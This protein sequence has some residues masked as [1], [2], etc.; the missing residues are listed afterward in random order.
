MTG[1]AAVRDDDGHHWFV[2]RA[3]DVIVASG[4]NVGPFEVESAIVLHPA[5]AESA[6][7]G[8]SRRGSVVKAFVVLGDD[9]VP[10]DALQAL[11]SEKVGRHASPREVEFIAE[12]PRTTRPV[13]HAG[14]AAPPPR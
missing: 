3:G 1:D 13:P 8:K 4:Y 11:V 10:N 14:L 6:V 2:G 5:A 12:L 9:V 7:V